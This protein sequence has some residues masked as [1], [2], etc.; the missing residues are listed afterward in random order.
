MLI[1]KN[2]AAE[3]YIPDGTPVEKALPRTT[4]LAIGAHQDDIEIMAV[5]GILKCYQKPAAWF[6]GAVVTNGSG[7][8]RSGLYA[9]TTD[10]EM[11]KIRV[12]E[13]KRAAF[14]GDYGAQVF[15]GYPSVD[16]K[17][18]DNRTIIEDIK[19]L[20]SATSPKVIYTH[21]LADKHATH[22]GLAVKVIQA[23][24]ELPVEQRPDKVYGCEVW[25]DLDWMMDVEKVVFDV[26]ALE[27]LQMALVGVFDSQVSGGKRYDLAAM[28]RRMANATFFASHSTNEAERL[29]FGMD[30]LPLV[31]DNSL[32]IKDYVLDFIHRFAADVSTM[33]ENV[34]QKREI[35]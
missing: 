22:V 21:N 34:S 17:D 24:R 35:E 9:G 31:Q 6:A 16:V 26:S 7:S 3:I 1:L 18:P 27:N 32:E 10:E 14:L 2:P 12:V 25:R 23:L 8:P 4:H 30:L 29:L 5:D 33:I 11:Q 28:G 19:T 15:L 20:V 13:Q